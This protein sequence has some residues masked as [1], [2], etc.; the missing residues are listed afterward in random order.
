MLDNHFGTDVKNDRIRS[1]IAR[2]HVR[3]SHSS[4]FSLH[5]RLLPRTYITKFNN[6]L[7][8]IILLRYKNIKLA[9]KT[10]NWASST[11]GLKTLPP[12]ALQRFQ[13]IEVSL[14]RLS[15]PAEIKRIMKLVKFPKS[16][17]PG[18]VVDS[19]EN[20]M[21]ILKA[22]LNYLSLKQL[23]LGDTKDSSWLHSS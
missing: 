20:S 4:E 23:S 21:R 1:K 7:N 16:A 11:K 9:G 5:D 3:S 8:E 12:N 22:A 19:K 17:V 6:P 15:R 18:G 10:S 13:E 2:K 14:F